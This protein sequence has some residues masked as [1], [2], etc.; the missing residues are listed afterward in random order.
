MDV[1]LHFALS[2]YLIKKKNKVADHGNTQAPHI[3]LKY[4]A[5]SYI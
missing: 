4:A 1:F 5:V 2:S 3:V